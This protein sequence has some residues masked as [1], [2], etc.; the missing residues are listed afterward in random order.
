MKES[1]EGSN[2]PLFDFS[3]QDLKARKEGLFGPES[4]FYQIVLLC[5]GAHLWF[6][7][8]DPGN[9]LIR[10]I[11]LD[12]KEQSGFDGPRGQDFVVLSSRDTHNITWK[13]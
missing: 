2:S 3:S 8:F 6:R 1:L 9:C 13:C 12:I 11:D 5:D 10:K 7:C 4:S